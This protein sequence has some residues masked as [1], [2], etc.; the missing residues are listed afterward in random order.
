MPKGDRTGP[1]GAGS[2]SGRGAGLCS[3]F[4]PLGG[5]AAKTAGHSRMDGRYRHGRR[6]GG[7]A[8]GGG[9]RR[10]R[11]FGFDQPDP[12]FAVG[13]PVQDRSFNPTS[14]EVSLRDRSRALQ[15]ELNAINTRLEKIEGGEKP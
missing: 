11:R 3:G 9:G 2:R 10:H 8:A 15:S 14:E 7:P 1:M 4:N 12:M 5:T 13:T 6:M